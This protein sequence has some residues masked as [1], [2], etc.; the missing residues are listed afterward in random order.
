[1]S[2]TSNFYFNSD[3]TA[4]TFVSPDT[5]HLGDP[6]DAFLLGGLDGSSEM[7]GGPTPDPYT[8]FWG[9]FIQ[10]DWKVNSRLTVNLGLRN[11]YEAAWHD[12]DHEL[13]QG[14]DLTAPIPE[15]QSN[16]PQMPGEALGLVGN[17][18]YKYNG[19][20]QFTSSSH[21][22]MWDPQKLALQPRVGLAYRIDDRT[23]LRFGYA[24]YTIPTEYNFTAA[25][26]AGFEDVNFLEPPFF[27]MTGYQF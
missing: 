13:S 9:M 21:P 22:G 12:P 23:V 17:N 26:F 19:L 8:E 10:D 16:P 5:L 6:F 20:W 15:M 11:E 4:N 7:I 25:P 14:L 27:G 2:N 24:R 1:M 18:F 3:L